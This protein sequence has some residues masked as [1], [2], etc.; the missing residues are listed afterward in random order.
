MD[1]KPLILDSAVEDFIGLWEIKRLMRDAG[2]ETAN[3][4]EM[5]RVALPAL[6]A[7]LNEGLVALFRGVQFAGEE[8]EIPLEQ[9]LALLQQP[10][11]WKPVLPNNPH[12]RL[13]AT[14]KG[15]GEYYNTD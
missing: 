6:G 8:K 9:A 10:N 2:I 4:S 3:D 15:G 5:R 7:L 12:L 11:S 13:C 14:A 1:I